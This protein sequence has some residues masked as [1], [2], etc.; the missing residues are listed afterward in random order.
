MASPAELYEQQKDLIANTDEL[1]RLLV[2]HDVS[3]QFA[4]LAAADGHTL[5]RLYEQA[6]MLARGYYM[7][8]LELKR[9]LMEKEN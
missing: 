2:K 4:P 7:E 3:L 6:L 5:R 9:M 8:N 1:A